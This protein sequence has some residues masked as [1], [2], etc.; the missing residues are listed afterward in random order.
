MHATMIEVYYDEMIYKTY[1]EK[2]PILKRVSL[3]VAR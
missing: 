2:F 3:K 1:K